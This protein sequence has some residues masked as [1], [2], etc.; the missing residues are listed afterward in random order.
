LLASGFG[1]GL[2][3]LLLHAEGVGLGGFGLLASLLGFLAALHFSCGVARARASR[4]S[5]ALLSAAI[6]ALASSSAFAHGHYAGFFGGLNDFA[7]G[8]DD[9]FLVALAAVHFFGVAELQFGLG[10]SGSGIFVG[11]RDVRDPHG[12]ARF[13]KFE[14]GLAVDA[15]DG[16][17]DSGVGGRIDAAAEQLVAGVDV[18]DFAEGGGAKDVFEHNGV[19]GCVTAKYGSAVTIMPK[20]C[21]S[22]MAFTSPAPFSAQFRRD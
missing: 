1:G 6:F 15:E 11:E 13:K 16:V 3:R 2:L 17:F 8:G 20:V 4:S 14:R 9:G 10:E 19:A 21:M 12:V 18:F 22:E 7:G 5:A